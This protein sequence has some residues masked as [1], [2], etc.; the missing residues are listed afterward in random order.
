[1]QCFQKDPN[2]RVS[3]RKL[4][5]H[6]WIVSAKR[7]ESVPQAPSTKYEEAVQ[8]IQKW[9]QKW[10][11]AVKSP[12][13]TSIKK[14]N[15]NTNLSPTPARR[16]SEFTTPV[17]GNLAQ[18]NKHPVN[19][20]AFRSPEHCE[21]HFFNN[22]M[23]L[24]DIVL[25][26][27]NWDDDFATCISPSALQLPHMKPHDN[28]GGLLSAER[29]KAFASPD[30]SGTNESWNDDFEGDPTMRSPQSPQGMSQSIIQYQ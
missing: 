21:C 23:L 26:E 3:A 19:T 28:F 7:A 5:K 20:D 25:V 9:N 1:M 12:N 30:N 22:M 11:E 17:R 6:P 2:L 4:L 15:R 18:N 24:S 27:D 16:Q 14:V 8:N 10:N 13:N 29:L